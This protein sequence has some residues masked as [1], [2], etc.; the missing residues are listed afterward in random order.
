M[1][2]LNALLAILVVSCVLGACHGKTPPQA[3]APP[4]VPAAPPP[5]PP[6]VVAPAAPQVDE[7]SKVKAMD[8]DAINR[9]GLL[10][11]VH[12]DY[13]K[14]DIRAADKALLERDAEQLRKYDFLRVTIEGHCDD[15][16]TVEYN[17]A[18]GERRARAAHDYLV[19]LG[20]PADH[21]KT[22]SYGKEAPICRESTEDC[23]M[24]NRR[25]HLTVTGKAVPR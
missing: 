5:A 10:Q 18:L 16:G 8:L 13:D 24:R 23:R 19:S 12:F 9:L 17:L 25:G 6:P 15:R 21:L 2:Q 4:V 22:V 20:V 14:A 1:R 3:P 11:E 7:Y